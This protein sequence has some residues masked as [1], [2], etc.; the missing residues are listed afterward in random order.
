MANSKVP[1]FSG[2]G[3]SDEMTFTIPTGGTGSTI[4]RIDFGRPYAFYVI[5][6][7]D[8]SR[9]AATTTMRAQGAT[10]DY[11]QQALCDLYELN[12]PAT[13]WVSGNLPTSGTL[14]FALTHAFGC[15]Y[16]KFILSNAASGGDVVLKI[17][18]FDPSAIDTAVNQ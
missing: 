16:L 8:C 4:E 1:N 14:M 11:P 9:I 15:R 7:E 2:Y 12:S 5:R 18:G 3:V 13:R 17:R 10:N 6:I